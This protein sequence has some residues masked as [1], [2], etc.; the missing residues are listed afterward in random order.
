MVALKLRQAIVYVA[1]GLFFAVA[2]LS[3]LQGASMQDTVLKAVVSCTVLV[4][5]GVAL[6]RVIEDAERKELAAVRGKNNGQRKHAPGG[7]PAAEKTGTG[8]T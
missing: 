6:V 1:T 3:Q 8:A 2:A 7:E 5:L 4:M